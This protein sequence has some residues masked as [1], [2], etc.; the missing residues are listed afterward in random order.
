MIPEHIQPRP[1]S[2]PDLDAGEGSLL[3][4]FEPPPPSRKC[5]RVRYGAGGAGR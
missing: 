4:I 2:A 3:E 1:C 5:P